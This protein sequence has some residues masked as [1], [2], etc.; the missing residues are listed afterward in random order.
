MRKSKE[1]L[2]LLLLGAVALAAL[3][4][5]GSRGIGDEAGSPTS[6]PRPASETVGE[7]E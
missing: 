5:V 7:K 6:D 1:A 2:I 3:L 4:Y